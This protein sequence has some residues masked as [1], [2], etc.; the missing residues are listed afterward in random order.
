MIRRP[1]RST[2]FPYTTLFRSARARG[3]A[4]RT[5]DA[6]RRSRR[7][8]PWAHP[9][10][11]GPRAARPSGTASPDRSAHPRIRRG[12]GCDRH[13]GGRGAWR[14]R[15]RVAAAP[16]SSGRWRAWGRAPLS[17]RRAW[18]TPHGRGRR[19]TCPLRPAYSGPGSASPAPLPG[20]T[21]RDRARASPA[22]AYGRRCRPATGGRARAA[23]SRPWPAPPRACC[24][25]GGRTERCR[26]TR[27][28][29]WDSVVRSLPHQVAPFVLR[30][31]EGLVG[32]GHEA[33]GAGDAI[34]GEGCQPDRDR[35]VERVFPRVG[36][37]V[38]HHAPPQA[39]GEDGGAVQRRLGHDD[40]ELFP[41]V[42]GDQVHRPRL[43]SQDLADLAQDRISR[44]VAARVVDQL[45]PVDVGEQDRQ[46]EIVPPRAVEPRRELLRQ[47]AAV[48]AAGERV[49]R[50]ELLEPFLVRYRGFEIVRL[51]D[52]RDRRA[53][54][55]LRKL[56]I[57]ARE[58]RV[59]ARGPQGEHAELLGLHRERQ[60][61]RRAG[62]DGGLLAPP[63]PPPLL[64][65][66]SR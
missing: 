31:I 8:A 57:G 6:A 46:G 33:V 61:P 20:G 48:Q 24:R 36:E 29:T 16:R 12:G 52:R 54:H 30:A 7:R 5:P 60:G 42:A 49:R 59:L 66:R 43:A 9:S 17:P 19:T 22:G 2:L 63:P 35:Q 45:E 13:S 65:T 26:R 3:A 39:F 40:D 27:S 53:N 51:L 32:E 18:S 64:L 1:P 55:R 23:A 28:R 47:G 21:R 37:I 38:V 15:P 34:V 10:P 44:K 62:G 11:R 25:R 4:R 58:R 14:A 56:G 50:R 41:S